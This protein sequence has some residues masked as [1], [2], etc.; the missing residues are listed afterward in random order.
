MKARDRLNPQ[1]DASGD[2]GVK[3]LSTGQVAKHLGVSAHMVSR[4]IDEGKLPGV[5][6][7]YSQ[8]RRVHPAALEQ[9]AKDHGYYKASGRGREI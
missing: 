7:P 3:W 9:F 6:I 2:F 1:F 4:W 5:R 8:H